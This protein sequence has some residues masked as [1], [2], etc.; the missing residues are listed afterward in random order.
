MQ[1]NYVLG[2]DLGSAS[3]GTA[4]LD[5]ENQSIDFVGVRIF[6]AAMDGDTD[7]GKEESRAAAR[8]VAR[9][10]RRQTD[11][12]RGRF[13][14]TFIALQ[15]IGLMP[16]G[17]RSDVL[18]ALQRRLEKRYPET[19]VLPYFLRARALDHAL[20][21]EELARVFYHLA[22]R[23]GFLSNRKID[24]A[25]KKEN[26]KLSD[27]KQEL[28][29]LTNALAQSGA[30]SLGEYLNSLDPHQA[31]FR[32][33]HTSRAMY[34]DEFSLIWE[35][36][37][38]HHPGLLTMDARERLFRAIFHQ[39]PLKDSS[40]K[41]GRCELVPSER[42]MPLWQPEAQLLRILGFVNNLR[43]DQGPGMPSLPL[44]T[45][46]REQLLAFLQAHPRITFSEAR[47]QLSLHESARFTIE[48]H[49]GEKHIPGNLTESRLR[50]A[51]P[52]IWTKLPIREQSAILTILD[53]GIPGDATDEAVRQWFASHYSWNESVLDR[54]VAVQLPEGYARFSLI[55]ARKLLPHV[56]AG[57]SV[58][59]AIQLAFPDHGKPQPPA[60]L[61]APVKSILP[62]LSNPNVIRS[63]TELRKVVNAIIRR[64][65]K[66]AEVHVE[67]ARE[68]KKSKSERANAVKSNR[69]REKLRELAISQLQAHDKVRFQ[70]PSRR[71]IEKLLLAMQQNYRC[72]YTG[73]QFDIDGLLGDH[74][75]FDVDHIVPYSRSLDD[76]FDNKALVS[77]DAN[78]EKGNRT[79]IEWLG[80]E[81]EGFERVLDAAIK[82]DSRYKNRSKINRI[83]IDMTHDK[84]LLA[85]FT[86]RQLVETR[87]ASKLACRYLGTLFGNEVDESGKRRVFACSGQVTARLRDLWNLNSILSPEDF[88]KSRDD[89]RHHSIDAVAIAAASPRMVQLMALAAKEREL[90]GQRRLIL[91]PPWLGFQEQIADKIGAL[92]VSLRPSRKL[93]GALHEASIYSAPR[94]VNGKEFVTIRKPIVDIANPDAIVDP[95]VRAAWIK[96]RDEIS[97]TSNFNPKLF[98]GNWPVMPNGVPIRRARIHKRESVVALSAGVKQRFVPTGSNHHAAVFEVKKK[99]G[100]LAYEV[101]VVSLLEANDRYRRKLDVVSRVTSQEKRFL[102]SISAGDIVWAN[103]PGMPDIQ[104]WRVRSM[105]S[106]G[107]ME[108]HDLRDARLKKDISLWQPTLSAAVAQGMR[109]VVISQLGEVLKAND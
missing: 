15:K 74:P 103:N 42:R 4:L 1:K 94:M 98:E 86:Q 75:R 21:T 29:D 68:L 104:L 5:F 40:D 61:L 8:R 101:E 58:T 105:R 39:R 109:K 25:P 102:F 96:K 66:P 2:I 106:N 60:D 46:Q 108:V 7:T 54:L 50:E 71:D 69:E 73:V 28:K 85:E 107:V 89:H 35:T 87:Y 91:S 99:N 81:S 12:R 38:K 93:A 59:E 17:N 84:D 82:M 72:L 26:E 32:N 63:L 36:Q 20:D 97:E 95:T 9:G 92:N 79:I 55:A 6:D 48:I 62:E 44:T 80:K 51:L 34:K 19:N 83:T 76:S 3:V 47:K 27:F 70:N 10:Q 49:G 88:K 67:L 13:H 65:G 45:L 52:G 14:R 11:R 24:K 16:L 77:T 100:K 23:R 53:E 64:Y 37:K 30:R 33:R 90:R 57:L 18:P 56:Q 78:R 22:Q 41:I 31:R 43:I